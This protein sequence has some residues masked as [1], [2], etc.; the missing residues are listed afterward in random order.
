MMGS[1]QTR[2]G[3]PVHRVVNGIFPSNCYLCSTG[4]DGECFVVDPGLDADV[5]RDALAQLGW[6]PSAVLCTHG[7]FDH[8]GSAAQ[9]AEG[10]GC[11]VHLHEHDVKTLRSS[12]FLLM[13]LKVG[14]RVTIPAVQPVT[15]GSR[16]AV[17]AVAV[18][19]H[20]APGH[21]P[22]S[23]VIEFDDT[24]FT[25]DS[26]YSRGVGLSR[27]PGEDPDQ[28]RASLQRLW[29]RFPD[30]TVVRP[31]HGDEA[32]FGWI[33]QHNEALKRFMA[34]PVHDIARP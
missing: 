25:G 14:V 2:S 9:L 17:G 5:V 13:A 18:T 19:F 26:L 6:R 12:N 11:P 10:F 4:V 21:T 1:S 28:L 23:A 29:T 8:T 24:L 22:G 16:V 7:H 33:K 32:G 15:D 30:S 34:T 31:G 27:L 3:H 20:A